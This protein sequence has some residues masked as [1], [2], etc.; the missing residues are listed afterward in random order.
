MK[1]HWQQQ[2]FQQEPLH[3]VRDVTS[4]LYSDD[5]DWHVRVSTLLQQRASPVQVAPLPGA[6]QVPQRVR[7]QNRQQVRPQVRRPQL[8]KPILRTGWNAGF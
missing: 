7:H 2:S 5:P 1:N 6:R 4:N 3:H 8:D